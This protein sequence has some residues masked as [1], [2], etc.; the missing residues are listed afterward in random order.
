MLPGWY[1]F[2][3]AQKQWRQQTLLTFTLC[4]FVTFT[5]M[6][7]SRDAAAGWKP[8]GGERGPLWG[9]WPCEPGEHIPAA[10]PGVPPLPTPP[11]KEGRMWE[12]L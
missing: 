9:V 8:E 7:L 6:T 3:S 10:Q 12:R 11:C 4:H 1:H 2:Q 5:L